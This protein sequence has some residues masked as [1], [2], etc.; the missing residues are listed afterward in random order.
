MFDLE[1][2]IAEWRQQMLVAGIK[3]P[4]PL[5][6]LEIHLREDIAQQT[7]SG[8]SEQR[9]FEIVLKKIGPAS[10]LNREFKKIGTPMKTPKVIRLAGVICF[11]VALFCQLLTCPPS[12]F[13]FL[14]AHGFRHGF[15]LSLVTRVLPLVVWSITVAATVLSW[16]YN[17]KLLPVI[18]DQL[19]RRAVG[20]VCFVGCLLWIRFVLFHLPKGATESFSLYLFLFGSEWT[21]LAILGG[22]GYGLE[23][24]ASRQNQPVVS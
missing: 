13:A 17:H 2:A 12:V 19:L 6:E 9:A 23:K 21:V 3:M 8:L 11:T 24:A 14:F 18:R 15:R 20:I 7:Q 5:E 16:K 4:V 1:Q 10:E 22:V